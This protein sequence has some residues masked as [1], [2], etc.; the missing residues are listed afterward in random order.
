MFTILEIFLFARRV[1]SCCPL[2]SSFGYTAGTSAGSAVAIH[3]HTPS[4]PGTNH[5]P[6]AMIVE[7]A[8]SLL[9]LTEE[10]I[11]EM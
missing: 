10:H 7:L 9:I 5:R 6:R 2:R 1:L 3:H 4:L 11:D 8:R